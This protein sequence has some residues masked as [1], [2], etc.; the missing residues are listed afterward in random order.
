MLTDPFS[1]NITQYAKNYPHLSLPNQPTPL[2]SAN[3]NPPHPP[4]NHHTHKNIS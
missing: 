1:P 4:P 3:P 2:T